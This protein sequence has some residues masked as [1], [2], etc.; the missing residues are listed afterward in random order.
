MKWLAR[1]W[2]RRSMR[3]RGGWSLA[4]NGR[5]ISGSFG[6]LRLR[7]VF[8]TKFEDGLNHIWSC[9]AYRCRFLSWFREGKKEKEGSCKR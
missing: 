9:L 8:A 6:E 4:T 5:F 2:V 3:L 7:C 1:R